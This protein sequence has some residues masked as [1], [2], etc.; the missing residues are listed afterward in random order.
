MTTAHQRF[1]QWVADRDGTIAQLADVLGCDRNRVHQIKAGGI[2]GRRLAN[3]IERESGDWAF[4]PI[5]SIEWDAA[6]D[7]IRPAS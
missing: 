2:P 5:R 1:A 4:G 6:E 3:A 7:Q